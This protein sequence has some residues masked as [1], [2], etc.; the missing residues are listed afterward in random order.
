MQETAAVEPREDR[1]PIHLSEH[2]P[3]GVELKRVPHGAL[4]VSFSLKSPRFACC[5]LLVHP[6]VLCSILRL[7]VFA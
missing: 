6:S 4:K 7:S 5:V 2:A 1:V 3:H